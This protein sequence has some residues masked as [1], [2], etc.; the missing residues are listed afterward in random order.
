M[1]LLQAHVRRYVVYLLVLKMSDFEGKPLETR[2]RLM[3]PGLECR[4]DDGVAMLECSAGNRLC[5]LLYVKNL[6]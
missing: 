1:I 3:V 2:R 6:E 5:C 4:L